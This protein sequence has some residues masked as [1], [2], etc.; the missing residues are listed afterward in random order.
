MDM[1]SVLVEET[2]SE[3]W[4]HFKRLYLEKSL[5]GSVQPLK[6]MLIFKSE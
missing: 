1:V 5:D 3:D 6:S 2:A 4:R